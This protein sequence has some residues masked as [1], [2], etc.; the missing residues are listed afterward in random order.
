MSVEENQ[1]LGFTP[2]MPMVSF[3]YA[4]FVRHHSIIFIATT[5]LQS[6]FDIKYC[7]H[8]ILKYLLYYYYI[9]L[10]KNLIILIMSNGNRIE[11]TITQGVIR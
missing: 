10:T 8:D 4:P 2:F 1:A 3:L 5:I 6:F 11:W 7:F 9:I